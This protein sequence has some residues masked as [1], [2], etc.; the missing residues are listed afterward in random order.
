MAGTRP[1]PY[2]PATLATLLTEQEAEAKIGSLSKRPL[3]ASFNPTG[4]ALAVGS[5]LV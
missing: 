2:T 4:V 3:T 5:Q 1:R